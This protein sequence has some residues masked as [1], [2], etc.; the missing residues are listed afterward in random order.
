MQKTDLHQY[1]FDVGP[2]K[3]KRLIVINPY[4]SKSFFDKAIGLL[5]PERITLVVDEASSVKEIDEIKKC[6]PPVSIKYSHSKS[7]MVHLKIYFFEMNDSGKDKFVFAWGSANASE[8]GFTGNAE[9]LSKIKFGKEQYHS[10]IDWLNSFERDDGTVKECMIDFNEISLILPSFSFNAEDRRQKSTL[11]SWLQSGVLCHKYDGGSDFGKISISLK[12]PLPKGST[13]DF[14]TKI[15]LLEANTTSN[16]QYRYVKTSIGNPDS[17]GVGHWRSEYFT[18]S[19]IGFWTSRLCY[20]KHRNEF[21]L[22]NHKNREAY[23][24]EVANVDNAQI[25]KIV[26]IVLDKIRALKKYLQDD[27]KKDASEYINVVGSDINCGDYTSKIINKIEY[28]RNLSGVNEFVE[29]FCCG[30]EFVQMPGFRGTGAF[31]LFRKSFFDS[32]KKELLKQKTSNKL[33]Q[34]VK[35]ITEHDQNQIPSPESHDF[36]DKA[37]NFLD[38]HWDMF[39]GEMLNF[40]RL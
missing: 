11:D 13:G 21:V 6:Y 7:G 3:V 10:L 14:L 23:I 33:A 15:G 30:F 34:I 25:S 16:L 40:Y 24:C 28:H 27:M 19:W 20:D 36:S 17:D 26:E 9:V 35:S 37:L 31:Q 12:K 18:E 32:I 38:D 2:R 5:R 29:R 39:S 22:K 4:P 1:L 8:S